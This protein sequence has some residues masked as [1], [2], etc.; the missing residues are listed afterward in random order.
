MTFLSPAGV[1][2]LLFARCPAAVA[3][4]VVPIVIDA[5][6]RVLW[7]GLVAHIGVKVFKLAPAFAD[8]NAAPSVP[9]K[10]LMLWIIAP[11]KHRIPSVMNWMSGHAVRHPQTSTRLRVV[12]PKLLS[13]HD[14]DRAAVTSTKPISAF[15]IVGRMETD[16]SEPI[17]SL[18]SQIYAFTLH[19]TYFNS[20]G[21]AKW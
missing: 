11:M 17:K 7:R 1:V 3:R 2:G 10:V 20:I 21:A 8:A 14:G 6:Q 5:L 13:A 16:D 18:S 9:L 15:L 4:L 19:G 12:A